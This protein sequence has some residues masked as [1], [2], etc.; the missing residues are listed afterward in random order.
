MGFSPTPEQGAW[1][2][3]QVTAGAGC[4]LQMLYFVC[5]RHFL[6]LVEKIILLSKYL[7]RD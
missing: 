1:L 2:R 4:R 3:F 6:A 7:Y 5:G